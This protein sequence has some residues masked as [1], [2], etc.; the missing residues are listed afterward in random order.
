MKAPA[1]SKETLLLVG[2]AGVGIYLVYRSVKGTVTAVANVN[3]G[4]PYE[5]TGVVGTLGNAANTA[6]GGTLAS[7]GSWLGG[8]F[9]TLVNGD[10]DPN[11]APADRSTPTQNQTTLSNPVS[12]SPSI[13]QYNYKQATIDNPSLLGTDQLFTPGAGSSGAYSEDDSTGTGA[14]PTS[15]S[16]DFGVTDP[17]QWN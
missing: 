10:Y 15:Y 2:L 6:S 13:L 11:A 1:I 12:A 17:T 14:G 5:G 16:Y 3:K 9:F 7:L 4:T 8:K